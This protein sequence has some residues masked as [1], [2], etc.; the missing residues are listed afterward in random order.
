MQESLSDPSHRCVMSHHILV[1]VNSPQWHQEQKELEVLCTRV[2]NLVAAPDQQVFELSVVFTCDAEI[3]KL[4]A[5]YRHQDKPTNVLSFPSGVR[6]K[7]QVPCFPLGDIVL[8]YETIKQEAVTQHKSFDHHL[9]HLLM[10]GFLHLLGYD[11]EEEAQANI[12][13]ALEVKYL[14]LLGIDNPYLQRE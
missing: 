11:H 8:A 3:Q 4:N 1:S 12:M 5:T 2:F 10:H 13:E 7:V 14:G 9:T 6:H